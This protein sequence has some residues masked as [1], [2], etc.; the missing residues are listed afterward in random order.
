MLPQLAGAAGPVLFL[1]RSGGRSQK[2][3]EQAVLVG[4]ADVINLEGGLLAWA[5]DVEPSFPGGRALKL[6]RRRFRTRHVA[7]TTDPLARR[8]KKPGFLMQRRRRFENGRIR[9]APHSSPDADRAPR[10]NGSPAAAVRRRVPALQDVAS[11]CSRQGL[12]S[13]CGHA[14]VA[15]WSDRAPARCACRGESGVWHRAQFRRARRIEQ[16]ALPPVAFFGERRTQVLRAVPH[17]GLLRRAKTRALRRAVT[18][19]GC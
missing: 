10:H 19:W 14:P 13:A 5:R 18:K 17:S 1:C 11:R 2:A 3:C 12:S 4:L 7:H 16:E 8:G 9:T 15:A 6:I